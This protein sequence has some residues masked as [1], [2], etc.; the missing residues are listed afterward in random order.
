MDKLIGYFMRAVKENYA[1]FKGRN[2]IPEFWWFFLAYVIL[3]VL[4]SIVAGV[5]GMRLL[6]SIFSLLMLL[7]ALG[8]GIRR[9]HDIGKSGWFILIPFYDLYL[10]AQ[11]GQNGPN[12]YGPDPRG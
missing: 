3:G 10:W 5:I 11:P 4:V 6:S 7:P 8:A 12:Q 2:T 9:M 1:N